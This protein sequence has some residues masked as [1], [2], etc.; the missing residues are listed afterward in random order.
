MIKSKNG[1]IYEVHYRCD[2]EM[3]IHMVKATNKDHALMQVCD[4]I[5]ISASDV[6]EVR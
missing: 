1:K 6:V 4:S 2:N 5:S 3:L